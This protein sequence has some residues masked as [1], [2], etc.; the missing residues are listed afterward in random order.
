MCWLTPSK[1]EKKLKLGGKW[2]SWSHKAI[3]NSSSLALNPQLFL[4]HL[5]SQRLRS[6]PEHH[7]CQP[8]L[9]S[10]SLPVSSEPRELSQPKQTCLIQSWI[11]G[12]PNWIIVTS[13]CFVT[14]ASHTQ[15]TKHSGLR[16]NEENKCIVY[17]PGVKQWAEYF[18]GAT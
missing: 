8:K 2:L 15:A 14:V 17:V 3:S 5:L 16:A 9:P 7:I 6:H 18:R 10:L 1:P 11:T 4:P 12:N 13:D